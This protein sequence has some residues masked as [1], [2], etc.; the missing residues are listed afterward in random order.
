MSPRYLSVLICLGQGK[1]NFGFDCI[2]LSQVGR[3]AF[4]ECCNEYSNDY[5]EYKKNNEK[6]VANF[7]NAKSFHRY[8][9]GKMKVRCN[10]CSVKKS[11][12]LSVTDDFAN[13][14]FFAEYFSGVF[15][16]DNRVVP[17][18]EARTA[19]NLDDLPVDITI[20]LPLSVLLVIRY[21]LLVMAFLLFLEANRLWSFYPLSIPFKLSFETSFVASLRK[22]TV[23]SPLLKKPP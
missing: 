8:V 21:L 6:N 19:V 2:V 18:F 4:E 13:V 10:T 9:N 1:R 11:T 3:Q 22:T 14:E 12:G 5:D 16:K 23:V 17:S 7:N 20:V 15:E